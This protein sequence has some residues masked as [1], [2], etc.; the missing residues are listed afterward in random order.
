MADPDLLDDET[1]LI[2]R[3][4]RPSD[5]V[6]EAMGDQSRLSND[7]DR[8]IEINPQMV[9]AFINRALVRV[10]RNTNWLTE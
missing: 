7:L 4:T 5:L 6:R 9:L 10:R 3:M 8:A 2:E 1:V